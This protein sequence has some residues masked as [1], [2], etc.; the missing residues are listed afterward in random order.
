VHGVR[1]TGELDMSEVIAGQQVTLL[2]QFYDFEGGS[3]TDLDATP[4]ITVTSIATGAT[5][6]SPTTS[7]VTHPATG[8]YGYAWTPAS[9]LTPGAYLASWSGLSGGSPVTAT[10]TVTVVAPASA[11]DTN[12]S[13]DRVWYATREEIKAELDVRETARSDARIDRAVEAASRSVEALCHRRFYPVQATR[14]FDWPNPQRAA[15][16]RLWLD[17]SELISVTTLAS[18]GVTIPATDFFL[19]PNQY[20]P[21][22]NRLEIDLDSS[23]AFGGGDTH[24]RDVQITGLW[25]YRNTETTLGTTTEA[26]DDSETSVDVD[27]ATSSAAGVGSILRVDSERMIVT[28]R[29]QSD[30]GQNLGSNLTASNSNTSIS[31]ASGAGFAVGEVILIDAEKMRIDDIAGNTLIVTRPWD[32]TTLAPHTAGADIYAPRTL[33]VQRAALGTTAADHATGS[34]VHQ[35]TPPG[36]IRQLCV[37]EAL[38]DLLQGRS[39]YARTAGAGENEREMTGR[40]LEMLRKRV[41][42]AHGRKARLRGV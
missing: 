42:A 36:D 33:T 6:L 34:T 1:D 30:T 20:G 25:G 8:S 21:P 4:T 13:P 38:N 15:S 28:G 31:V 17:A 39:G 24:Q 16:W 14:F 26:L 9:S 19:E 37:A 23:A 32:G 18:G 12:T 2:A 5:V 41:Y 29:T 11:Q 35:W 7:G 3:L 40:G 10:E 22:Y 27:A